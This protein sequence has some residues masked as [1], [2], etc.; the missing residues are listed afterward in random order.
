MSGQGQARKALRT[1]GGPCLPSSLLSTL[2]A[3]P[4]DTELPA[5][6]PGLAMTADGSWSR[7][8]ARTA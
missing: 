3:I 5:A 7:C 2:R 1:A 4:Q 8:R 6:P